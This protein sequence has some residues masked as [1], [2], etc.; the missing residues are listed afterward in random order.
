M[1]FPLAFV[2]KESWTTPPRSFGAARSGT[3]RLHGA[4]DLYAPVGT[5]VYAI[6][7]GRVQLGPYNFYGPRD[8]AIEVVNSDG[9][10]WRYCELVFP[11]YIK[12]GYVVHEGEV[13]GHI[14]DLGLDA[15][16]I[17]IERFS[18]AAKG[19]LTV[20]GA[21]A[22]VYGRRSDLVDPTAIV[23]RLAAEWAAKSLA[24]AK[25]S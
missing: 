10:I 6:E 12:P 25:P 5:P 9:S 17:H 18:G 8:Y 14:A 22:G 20:K 15:S 4:V 3:T 7:D 11:A 1:R 23:S 19:M 16:M 21:N 13:I 2:P 24:A